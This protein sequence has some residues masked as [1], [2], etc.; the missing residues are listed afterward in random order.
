MKIKQII[1][2][3]LLINFM[4]TFFL[5]LCTSVFSLNSG[6]VFSQ[7]VFIEIEKDNSL[8]IDQVFELIRDQTDYTFIYHSELFKDS[9]KIKVKKGSIEANKLLNK[10]LSFGDFV[11]TIKENGLIFLESNGPKEL[12]VDQKAIQGI[13]LDEEGSPL[14]G[15]SVLVKGST[16]GTITNFDGEYSLMFDKDNVTLMFSYIGYIT[17]EVSVTNGSNVNITLL[18]DNNILDEIVVVGYGSTAKKDLTGSVVSI[19]AAELVKQPA[20]NPMESLQGKAAGVQISTSG[21][22][23]SSPVVVIRGTGTVSAGRNPAYVVDGILQNSISNINS[24][25]ILSMEI[26]KDASSLA[27]FGNRGANGVIVVTTKSGKSGK[28]RIDITSYYGIKQIS[29]KVDMADSNSFVH[30]SNIAY[31]YDRFSSNQEYNTDWF[32]EITQTGTV[33]SHNISLSSGNEKVTSFFSANYYYEDGTQKKSDFKRVNLRSKASYKFFNDKLTLKHNI[34]ASIVDFH[35]PDNGLFTAA[36]RQ[37]PIVPVRYTRGPYNGR[38]G[39][40]TDDEGSFNNVGNPV[41]SLE[42]RDAVNESFQT[43]GNFSGEYKITDHLKVNSSFGITYNTAGS[44]RFT[45]NKQNWVN[46]DPTRDPDNY[47]FALPDAPLNTLNETSSSGYDWLWNGFLTYER[48][49]NNKHGITFVLGTSTEKQN[50]SKSMSATRQNVN[51]ILHLR[52]LSSGDPSRPQF[53]EGGVGQILTLRSYFARANYKYLDKYLLTATIRKDGSSHFSNK[54]KNWGYFPSLGLGWVVS[55]ENYMND[56]SF[57][58]FLKVRGSWGELGNANVPLNQVSVNSG[59]NYPFGPYDQV[60]QIGRTITD[61]IDLNLGW[62]VTQELD[63]GFE[64]RMLDNRLSGEFDYYRRLNTNV[65]LPIRLDDAFGAGNNPLT[66]AAEVSNIGVELALNWSDNIGND[67]KYHVSGNI[68]HNKNKLDRIINPDAVEQQGGSLGNGQFTKLLEEGEELG[69]FYLWENIGFDSNGVP[70][71]NDVNNDGVIDAKDRKFFGSNNPDYFFGLSAGFDYKGID[72]EVAGY[73]NVGSVIYNGK[74]A[75][76]WGGENIEQR[77]VN[78]EFN[79]DNPNNTNPIASNDVPIA[80][81]YYLESGDYFRINNI[82]LGY[83]IQK[84]ITGVSKIRVF[85]TAQSPFT[86]TKYSGYT[87]ELP[88]SGAPLGGQGIELDI[89]PTVSTYLMGLNINF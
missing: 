34:S 38:Y 1:R 42:Q 23:G 47:E 20:S 16:T 82:T 89:H 35:A 41:A 28:S 73:G 57:I 85:A 61:I 72:F 6:F 2:K 76:R 39:V 13:V 49:F 7:N 84:K 15:V 4:R 30:F 44:S 83:T 11:F 27:V 14:P 32:D 53:S 12:G 25:D 22:P 9:P 65:I 79:P 69:S 70:V 63:L 86:F 26:L 59:L 68:S 75:Q 71:Y 62:E 29:N 55:E 19:K 33:Q 40:S 24:E 74:K 60:T 50:V 31:K 87:P 51:P 52:T 58:N 77:V 21:Q 80:S 43:I 88:S 66:H 18:P 10:S 48:D 36:Y 56:L 81:T 46:A 54:E 64:F 67:F 45:D 78:F 3:K 17:Q 37:A 5:L 8:S